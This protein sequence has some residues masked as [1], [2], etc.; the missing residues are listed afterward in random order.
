MKRRRTRLGL[1]LVVAGLAIFSVNSGV[2]GAL[3][4][5]I[6]V[7]ALFVAG[8]YVW[9][10][11]E[12]RLE[13]WQRLP[14]FV[15]FGVLA[16]ATSGRFAGTAAV[17]YPAMAFALVYLADARRWWAIIPAGVLGS[18]ALLITAEE[19]FPRWDAAPVL[20][21]GFAATFTLLY[22]L[23]RERGGRRWALYP[24]I[25][26]IVLTVLVNDPSGSGP[27]WLF[28]LALIGSGLAILWWWQRR[29]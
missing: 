12:G 10:L 21:L 13:T 25:G 1:G 2:F 9:L 14:L 29:R 24:A 7:S 17:G 11:S 27:G 4:A 20:F 16:I 23:P 18:V 6:W 15:F 28:P 3:P 8:A 19:L 26:W 5:F 22:L